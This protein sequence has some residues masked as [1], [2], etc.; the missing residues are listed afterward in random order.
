MIERMTQHTGIAFR[1]RSSNA[2]SRSCRAASRLMKSAQS[3]GFVALI[4]HASCLAKIELPPPGTSEDSS[5]GNAG[6]EASAGAGALAESPCGGRGQ[7]CCS[8]PQPPCGVD[9]RCDSTSEA[10]VAAEPRLCNPG[11]ELNQCP[12]GQ[13]CCAMGLLGSCVSVGSSEACPAPDLIIAT[14][15]ESFNA[16]LRR[17]DR[18]FDME[19]PEDRCALEKG[20]IGGPGLRRLLRFSAKVENQGDADL[21][22]GAPSAHD[23]FRTAECDGQRYF[24]EYLRYDLLTLDGLVAR[25]AA[26]DTP[27]EGQIQ[28]R[29]Q[30]LPEGFNSRFN[31]DF[32]GLW[33]GYSETFSEFDE[34]QWLDIT[35][36][37]AGEYRLR[38][39]VNSA[40][41]LSE[42]LTN[43]NEQTF[44]VTIPAL[45]VPT[46]ACPASELDEDLENDNPL[47]GTSAT[48]ECGWVE[49]LGS[50][51]SQCVPGEPT[52]V[53][54]PT[55]TGN[56][57]LRVCDASSGACIAGSELRAVE[58]AGV[59]P[60]ASFL[61]P[62]SGRHT[63]LMGEFSP[64]QLSPC[65]PGILP[66]QS[67]TCEL[68]A[69]AL[70]PLQACSETSMGN[71]LS[72]ECG[73]ALSLTGECS[74]AATVDLSCAPD[75]C[76]GDE[77]MRVCDGATA[78][79]HGL[80]LGEGDDTSNP[81][82]LCPTVGFTCP[83]SGTYTVL[84]AAYGSVVAGCQPQESTIAAGAL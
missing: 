65:G 27:V 44:A 46:Q 36:V 62:Q 81:F 63:T 80:M 57:I 58:T 10:C 7:A 26:D 25:R 35:G 3:A 37:E 43:N 60:I 69:L 70:D 47:W 66:P 38:L 39:R 83:E 16:S 32:M 12:S 76:V 33:S 55:C 49:G 21:I 5:G 78:C 1:W 77:M 56:P 53:G 31:C 42:E 82:S 22:L 74:P 17:E 61:C 75:S 52:H 50:P 41:R 79:A 54:C 48:R 11:S 59:C 2:R 14:T 51:A 4:V 15:E 13:R 24:G 40:D 23:A 67:S 72:S 6:Q 29:C 71:G 28:A 68:E 34:C 84:V 64:C 18:K 8:A 30:A 19:V 9:L 45:D 20:C 73:W